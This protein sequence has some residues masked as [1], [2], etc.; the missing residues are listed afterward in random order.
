MPQDGDYVLIVA[1][2]AAAS[3]TLE[4]EGSPAVV[5]AANGGVTS[6]KPV[7][8][9]AGKFTRIRIE[10][11]S[12]SQNLTLSWQSKNIGTQYIPG[13]YLYSYTLLRSLRETYIRFLKATSL[14]IALSLEASET[15]FLGTEPNLTIPGI[16]WINKLRSGGSPDPA[17]YPDL[18]KALIGILTF[19]R[20]KKEFSPGDD[21]FMQVLRGLKSS[22][23]TSALLALTGW[24]QDSLTELLTRFFGNANPANLVNLEN[25]DRV[26]D[27]YSVVNASGIS[28][29][30]L[31]TSVTNDPDVGQVNSLESA[32]AS[33]YAH[34]TG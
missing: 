18:L 26:D 6:F 19:A 8:F 9:T 7:T 21:R 31:D 1:S 33:R 30:A 13:E 17:S 25:F 29:E 2:D 5:A 12:F 22:T 14:S 32:V 34:A 27:A 11:K 23:D 15:A 28:A 24:S 20:L 4:I 3:I 10:A 16:G